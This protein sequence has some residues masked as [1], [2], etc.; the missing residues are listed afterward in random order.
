MGT[1]TGEKE[2]QVRTDIKEFIEALDLNIHV[3]D[4]RIAI[5]SKGAFV[6]KL[7]KTVVGNKKETRYLFIEFL[8]FTDDPFQGLGN[9]PGANITYRLH[10]FI[11]YADTRSDLTNSERDFVG[12]IL[13]LRDAFL[14]KD[15]F[16]LQ[17]EPQPLTIEQFAAF[18]LD[19]LTETT[20][21]SQ[22]LVLEVN[23]TSSEA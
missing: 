7:Q 11:Q 21:H 19:E 3:F 17:S 4:R 23:L 22:D 18:G 2:F 14:R 1:I 10:L 13:K 5:E 16:V 8:R 9:C 12:A 15:N 6:D 20:G